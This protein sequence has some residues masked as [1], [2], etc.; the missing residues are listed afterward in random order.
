[1]AYPNP[2]GSG[3][4]RICSNTGPVSVSA[5]SATA[6]SNPEIPN[7]TLRP[8]W[9]RATALSMAF[10]AVEVSSGRKGEPVCP[11]PYTEPWSASRTVCQR[12]ELSRAAHGAGG[13]EHPPT[14]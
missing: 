14:C 4:T 9:I 13:A 12:A 11:R 5:A 10:P 7:V 3:L 6:V 8:C 1:M 2:F